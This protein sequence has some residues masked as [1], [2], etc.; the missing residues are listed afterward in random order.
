M[1]N[2]SPVPEGVEIEVESEDKVAV[3]AVAGNTKEGRE[4]KEE[5]GTEVEQDVTGVG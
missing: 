1:A 3:A 5:E 2:T 4:E